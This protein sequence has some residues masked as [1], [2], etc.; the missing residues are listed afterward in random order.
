[1]STNLDFKCPKCGIE[2]HP[3]FGEFEINI[4]GLLQ[5]KCP[6]GWLIEYGAFKLTQEDDIKKL[7]KENA[8]SAV[9]LDAVFLK[10]TGKHQKTVDLICEHCGQ[11]P[12]WPHSPGCKNE[13]QSA[14]FR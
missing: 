9:I 6:C 8:S 10:Y 3:K 14:K 1:M 4:V 2:C 13:P 12:G 11:K 5:L 7:F